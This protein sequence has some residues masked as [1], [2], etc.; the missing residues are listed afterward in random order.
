MVSSTPRPYF[1]LGKDPIP[2]VQEAGW[3]PGPVWTDGKSHP[4]GIRSPDR[5]ARSSVA[6][7]TEL[8]GPHILVIRFLKTMAVYDHLSTHSSENTLNRRTCLLISWLVGWLVC[9]SVCL[10]VNNQASRCSCCL[11][12]RNLIFVFPCIILYGFY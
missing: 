8:P 3:A 7:P 4:T 5:P 12:F 2:I 11:T 6:I 9:M 1:T 10:S